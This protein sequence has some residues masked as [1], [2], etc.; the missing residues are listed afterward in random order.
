MTGVPVLHEGKRGCGYRKPGGTYLVGGD[1]LAPCPKLPIEVHTC[2]TCGQGVKAARGWTWIEY[3]P[4]VEPG[5]HGDPEHSAGCVLAQPPETVTTE[6]GKVGLIWVGEMHY[7]TPGEFMREALSMGLSRRVTA[8]PRGLEVGKTLVLLGH[9]KAIRKGWLDPETN[10][11]YETLDE[12]EEAGLNPLDIEPNYVAGVFTAFVPTAI[13]YVLKPEEE[14]DEE[15]IEVL[16][17]R[18][19][20]PVIVRE[21]REQE[22][23]LTEVTA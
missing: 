19:I 11:V 18:G 21:V 23:L 12:V 5:P 1:T 3:E 17:E 15:R 6:E 7:K 9:R 14:N 13:E 16:R 8:I 10:A 4:F 2:P 20:T 22:D